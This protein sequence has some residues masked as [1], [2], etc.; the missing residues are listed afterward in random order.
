MAVFL[1]AASHGGW[2]VVRTVGGGGG[3][4]IGYISLPQ[5]QKLRLVEVDRECVRRSDRLKLILIA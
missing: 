5:V 2:W 3:G 1:V 4:A